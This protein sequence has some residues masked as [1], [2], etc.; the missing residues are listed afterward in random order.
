M[1]N[2]KVSIE[3]GKKR[4][5]ACAIDWPGWCRNSRDEQSS[6]VALVAYGPRYA[7]VIDLAVIDTQGTEPLFHPPTSD[8]QFFVVSRL[9]GNATTDFGAPAISLELDNLPIEQA[10][11]QRFVTILRACWGT[12]DDAI[13]QAAGRDLR[14]GPRGGGKNLQKIIEHVL[15]A[16]RS[17]LGRLAWKYKRDSTLSV[18]EQLIGTRSA[19]INALRAAL[20]DGLPEQGPRAGAIWLPR[21]FIRRV[22]WHVLD[23][24]WE[25]EDRLI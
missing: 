15:D 6:L 24:T 21:Y 20:D 18:Q 23:H 3:H 4:T 12:F 11:H 1:K 22:A 2:I 16:D 9:D 7:K 19:I 13:Q 14:L 5:F 10:Q 17:Y 25:I 8:T